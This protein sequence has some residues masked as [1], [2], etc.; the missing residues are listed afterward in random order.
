MRAFRTPLI[1]TDAR[2]ETDRVGLVVTLQLMALSKPS[3]AVGLCDDIDI[4]HGF[5]VVSRT[6]KHDEPYIDAVYPRHD[7]L[8]GFIQGRDRMLKQ[9]HSDQIIKF[10]KATDSNAGKIIGLA[11]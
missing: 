10:V 9:K 8:E 11:I 2:K 3:V 7:T 5:R 4:D 1:R 6:F